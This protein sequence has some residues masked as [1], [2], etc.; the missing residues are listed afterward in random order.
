[1]RDGVDLPGEGVCFGGMGVE[2]RLFGGGGGG[3]A[4]AGEHGE[5]DQQEHRSSSG[6]AVGLERDLRFRTEAADDGCDAADED[7][8]LIE[9]RDD[10]LR[11]PGLLRFGDL[12]EAER[13]Q[14]QAEQCE[15]RAPDGD[16]AERRLLGDERHVVGGGSGSGHGVF[17]EE[18]GSSAAQSPRD[19]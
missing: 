4:S 10:V 7:Q 19:R 8:H 6:F 18:I 16:G 3:L 12:A 1:M 5:T 14:Q 17:L 9:S 11:E 15:Q 13:L 2:H